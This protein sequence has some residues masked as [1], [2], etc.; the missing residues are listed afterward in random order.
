MPSHKIEALNAA[1]VRCLCGWTF[2]LESPS[3]WGPRSALD[4]LLDK[5][6]NHKRFPARIRRETDPDEE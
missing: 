2:R 5:Y 1:I 3:L 6:N 4:A